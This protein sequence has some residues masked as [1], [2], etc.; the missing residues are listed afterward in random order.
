MYMSHDILASSLMSRDVLASS[1]ANKLQESEGDIRI[2]HV[3]CTCHMSYISDRL[4]F[5]SV[6]QHVRIFNAFVGIFFFLH[7]WQS[8]I[9]VCLMYMTCLTCTHTCRSDIQESDMCMSHVTC[10]RDLL[11][12]SLMSRDVLVWNTL[13]RIATHCNTCH[14][15][16]Q[17]RHSCHVTS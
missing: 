4:I 14:M 7:V 10:K 6:I 13:Q 1:L 8:R 16:Y 5:Y 3:T 9:R 12:S 15:T 11:A 17:R 2:S